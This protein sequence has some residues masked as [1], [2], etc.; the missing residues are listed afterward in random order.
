VLVRFGKDAVGT[1][2][3]Q[4][5]L[6]RNVPTRTTF[7]PDD[8]YWPSVWSPDGQ[9]VVF[10]SIRTRSGIA[11]LYQRSAAGSATDELLWQS[12]ES[13]AASGFSPDGSILLVDRYNASG[14]SA[15]MWALPMTGDRKPFPLIETAF[16]ENSAVFSP[17]GRFI[18]YV[19]ND[20]GVSQVYVQPFPPT[21][22]RVQ[23]S[24]GN[25]FSP[26]W[27]SDGRTVLYS[28]VDEPS[29]RTFVGATA[30][31]A[32]DVTTSGSTVRAGSPRI[33]FMQRNIGGGLHG[34]A[35]DPSGQRFLLVVPDE[36]VSAPITV[37]LNWPSLLARK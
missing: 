24:S 26:D 31:M 36:K 1:D 25:G 30:F 10:S 35:V 6:D 20:S 29:T 7:H 32:V 19:S 14:N 28:T 16:N 11:D 8:D 13:K 27:T 22:A 21:G 15:D 2:L 33:L 23:L 4:I 37:V 34:F 9:R 5:D 17:S 18:A 3:W 12:G